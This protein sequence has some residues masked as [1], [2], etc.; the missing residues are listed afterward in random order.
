MQ[1]RNYTLSSGYLRDRRR[2]PTTRPKGYASVIYSGGVTIGTGS[3]IA[4]PLNVLL[5]FFYSFNLE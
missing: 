2:L 3:R 1:S 5:A 4:R